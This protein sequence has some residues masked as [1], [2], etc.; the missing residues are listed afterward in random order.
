MFLVPL[1]V[2]KF[3]ENT[4]KKVSMLVETLTKIL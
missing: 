2:E 3:G 4:R 1:L